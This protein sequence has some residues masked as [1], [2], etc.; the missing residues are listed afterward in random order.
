MGSSIGVATTALAGI[1][2]AGAVA[3]S[4]GPAPAS[5]ASSSRG[6]SA[7]ARIGERMFH[8]EHLSGSGRMSCAS[9][10]DPAAHYA[11]ANARAVQ[12][13]GPDLDRPGIRATP[14]LT[15]KFLTRS[16]SVGPQSATG[17]AG[18]ATP[19]TVADSPSRKR[20]PGMPAGPLAP[21][22]S[23]RAKAA[24]A[25]PNAN[26]V[27]EGGMFW[28]GRADTLEEQVLGPLLSQFEMANR[29]RETLYRKIRSAYG[30]ELA[31]LF[32]EQVLDNRDMLLSEAAFAI[33][34][35]ETEAP[36][37]HAFDS[38]YDY[39]LRGQVQLSPQ[40]AR[41]LKLFDDPGKGNCS[42][43]HL[44]R[45]TPD[46]QPPVFTDYE[47]EALGVPRNTTIPA[48]ADPAHFD[49]GICGPLRHD[50]YARQ[51]GNCGL[52]KTPTLRNVATRHAF[53]HNGVFHTLREVLE[54]YA[55]RDVDPARFYPLR[56]DGTVDR[57]ND[58]PAEYRGNVDTIDAPLDR[59]PGEAP[60]LDEQ[61]IDDIVAF[62][63]TL[64]DGYDP[65][66]GKVEATY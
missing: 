49:L 37:F 15:Y 29:D 2:L 28:D 23:G 62:L 52:F 34:R 20:P 40:E 50:V 44:D 9:C 43:C 19:M 33:A 32:G 8:D 47:Y 16:F 46:G 45:I 42:S 17:E 61:E 21:M 7:V 66:T 65:K 48:N 4:A 25:S 38:K 36:A 35:Y 11:P 55:R 6:L 3:A 26:M 41:G 59:K 12:L 63:K 39:Y 24:L 56:Q 13:G 1:L 10:H 14:T 22:A 58:L 54:F 27:P 5:A 57:F 53:F 31:R 64:T 51:P 18:E 30:T 60:A